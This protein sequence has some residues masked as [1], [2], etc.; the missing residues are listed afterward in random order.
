MLKKSMSFSAARPRTHSSSFSA[1][2]EGGGNNPNAFRNPLLTESFLN[3]AV[4]RVVEVEE[5]DEGDEE[6]KKAV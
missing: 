6:E 3:D 1:Y 5:E 4:D 2:K